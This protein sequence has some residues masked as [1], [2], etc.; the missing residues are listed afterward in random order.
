MAEVAF[1][2]DG[3]QVDEVFPDELL[4]NAEHITKLLQSLRHEETKKVDLLE[5]FTK[6]LT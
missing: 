2:G 1:F 5:T 6:M 3:S 4:L